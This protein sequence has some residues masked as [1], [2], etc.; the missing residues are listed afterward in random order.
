VS[1]LIGAPPGY[2]GF[3]DGNVGGGKLISDVSKH[4]YSILLFDEIEKA[5]PDVVNIML[6]MLDEGRVTGSNG[7]TVDIKNSIIILTSNLGAQDNERNAIGFGAL[8]RSGEEDRAMKE[9]FRPELRNRIDH[10]CKFAK[11]DTLAVKK[12]VVKFLD[13]LRGTLTAKNIRIAWSEHLIQHLADTGY[14]PKMGARPLS[15]KIDELVRVPLSKRIL[16]EHLSDCD[17][18]ADYRNNQVE[19]DIGSDAAPHVDDQGFVR[20]ED[21]A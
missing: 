16:F 1:S 21:P 6:Q 8:E 13:Q 20:V 4:P 15:R 18:T 7:K 17:I 10:V 5:H 14:D 12:I 2:V 3:E 19:F 11:L 9:F